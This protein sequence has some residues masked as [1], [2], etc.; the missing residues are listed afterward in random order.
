MCT[1]LIVVKFIATTTI[2]GYHK[3]RAGTRPAT[4]SD[5][6]SGLT[7]LMISRAPEDTRSKQKQSFRGPTQV[8]NPH[9]KAAL[10]AAGATV[11][12]SLLE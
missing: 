5:R 7:S 6:E 11:L 1:A 10:Q 2:Q 3:G 8:D 12:K 9:A 4:K